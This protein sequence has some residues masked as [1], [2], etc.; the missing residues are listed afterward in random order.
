V[1]P[2]RLL[3]GA[4]GFIAVVLLS[5][6]LPAQRRTGDVEEILRAKVLRVSVRPGFFD[7]GS[8]QELSFQEAELL[9]QFAARLGVEI[10]WIEA[11]R[12]D[13]LLALV[14]EGSADIAVGRYAVES[15]AEY[16]LR[17]SAALGWVEDLLVASPGAAT[18]RDERGSS[19]VHL[20]RSALTPPLQTYLSEHGLSVEEVAEEVPIEEVLGRVRAGR[21]R[22]TVVDSQIAGAVRTGAG[23]EVVDRIPVRRPIVWAVRESNPGLRRA[24]DQYLFAESVLSRGRRDRACRD[25]RNIRKTRV[26]RMVTR[27]SATTVTIER[28]G[29]SGFEYELALNFARDLGVR[30]E[31]SIPP[32][33]VDPLSWLEQGY[34]D[35]AALHEPFGL[36]AGASFLVSEPYRWVDLVSVVSSRAD[37]PM[38]VEELAGVR[39]MASKAE[40]SLA[41]IMPLAAPIRARPPAVGADSFNAM[42]SVARGRAPVAVVNRDAARL[43][44]RSRSDL[45]IGAVVVP[46]VG[47]VWVLNLSSPR[48]HREVNQWLRT[49]RESGLVR[50]LAA[51]QFRRRKVPRP[52]AML[53]I[54]DGALSPYDELLQWV[55]RTYDIDWRLLASLMYEESRFDPD[56]VGPGGSAGLF[57]FMP[58]TWRELGVEDPHHPQEATEAA[59]RYLRQLMD[60]FQDLPLRDRVAMAIASYN[61]G[62]GHVFDARKLAVEMGLDPNRWAGSVE[63]AMLILDDPE[64]ARRFSAGVCAC[65]RAV[66]YT[67]RILR[68]YGAYTEQFPPA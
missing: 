26:I 59:G 8:S 11:P 39:A 33:E 63:T 43:A 37:L 42:L 13:R 35:I 40:A 10:R 14:Q 68:R 7:A 19:T 48:L 21:Y 56:A 31:L 28:G 4:V 52:L 12:G 18:G 65:R 24:I 16:G 55:G 9:R 38:S 6:C 60:E 3:A 45:Q 5:A 25:L 50:Q 64:V 47:L 61:V 34:G 22:L 32:P 2:R 67:R 58:S 44:V 41:R 29:L 17:A 51:N 1:N 30:L 27:N 62:P 46:D 20:H 23:L 53:P 66:G 36:D 15:L 57:Q 54:P 49:A